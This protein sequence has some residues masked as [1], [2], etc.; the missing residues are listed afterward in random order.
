MSKRPTMPPR[1]ATLVL[2][3]DLVRMEQDLEG[4]FGEGTAD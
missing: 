3:E 1:P 4:E 2:P